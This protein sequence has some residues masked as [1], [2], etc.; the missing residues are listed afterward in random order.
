MIKKFVSVMA[1]G[2]ALYGVSHAALLDFTVDA[3]PP[4]LMGSIGSVDYKVTTEPNDQLNNSQLEDGDTCE[5]VL[6]GLAC[7]RDGFGVTDDEVSSGDR[8][9]L[10]KVTFSEAV[11]I[12]NFY[13]LDL[14]RSSSTE[15]FEVGEY[16]IDGGATWQSF[17]SV[18]N[19][20]ANGVNSGALIHVVNAIASS[21]WFRAPNL[22]LSNNDN[23]GV[24]DFAV[25][26]LDVSEIPIP[27]AAVLLLTGMAGF[28]FASRK[29][30]AS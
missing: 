9:E 7:V 24:N 22:P 13:I 17:G 2:A 12:G 4:I 27:G 6:T 16:S 23:L 11:S 14:F 26:G 18:A 1:A 8:S 19:E 15:N 25:A 28:G 3:T 10:I 20:M 5:T 21:I 30:K 29:R